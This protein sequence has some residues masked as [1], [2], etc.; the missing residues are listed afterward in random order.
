MK[1]IW[2]IIG[3]IP[4]LSWRLLKRLP[5]WIPEL[6]IELPVKILLRLEDVIEDDFKAYIKRKTA[7]DENIYD[8]S[9]VLTFPEYYELFYAKTVNE[10]GSADI[11]TDGAS[12]E[13]LREAHL[14]WIRY[15]MGRPIKRKWL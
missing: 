13:E 7:T 1:D 6:C 15:L 9:R 11:C 4:D 2:L 12:S 3:Y 5:G 10:D 14:A 8:D